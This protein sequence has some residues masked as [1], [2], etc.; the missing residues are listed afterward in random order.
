VEAFDRGCGVGG[1]AQEDDGGIGVPPAD[2]VEKSHAVELRHA[3]VRDDEGNLTG[4]AQELERL[5]S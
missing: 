1:A 5:L 4:C 3:H 2:L